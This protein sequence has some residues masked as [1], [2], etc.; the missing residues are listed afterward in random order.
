[1][2]EA[3]VLPLAFDL[4]RVGFCRHP[5]C[6]VLR[7]AGLGPTEFPSLVGLFTHPHHGYM[8]YDTGYSRHFHAATRR[9]PE[10]LYR[11]VT[12]VTLPPEHELPAQ[13]AT[14][15]LAPADIGV[16]L[17][18]HFHADHVAG[19]RDFPRARFIATRAERQG[20]EARGRLGRLRRAYLREL[21]PEDFESRV[22]HAEDRPVLP[23]PPGWEP[24]RVG[25][26]LLGDGSLIG[27]DLPGHTD[28][29]LGLAFRSVEGGP[30]LLVGDACWKIEGLEQNRRP[31]RVA[32]P[33]F[34]DRAGYDATFSRLARLHQSTGAP[35]IIPSHCQTSWQ[36]F[37]GT[38]TV[39]RG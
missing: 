14:R 11:A 1:M 30:T 19:L 2:T 13:L 16:I 33:L 21:L 8:L 10:C 22:T 23:L 27:L 18:S 6:M 5:E 7:G 31:S 37:G 38:R 29:Q 4:L 12:P 36:R 25:R 26:D 20:N 34:A 9:F 39:F 35:R 3:L 24:F 15:G 28:S 17:I 32:Y